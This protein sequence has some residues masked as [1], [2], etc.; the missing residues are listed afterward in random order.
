MTVNLIC[1]FCRFSKKVPRE[2]IPAR[3]KW[4][5]CPQCG[6]RFKLF[7]KDRDIDSIKKKTDTGAEYRGPEPVEM[8]KEIRRTDAPW[9]NRNEL[10]FLQGILQTLKGVLFSPEKFFKKLGCGSGIKEPLAFALL[11]G[12]VGS[13]FGFFWQFLLLSGTLL[14]IAKSFFGQSLSVGLIFL[15]VMVFI[16]VF[17][18]INL[19]IYSGIIHVLMRIVG[20]GK[21]GFEATFRVMSYCHAAQIWVIIPFVGSWIGGIWQLVVQIIGLREIHRTSYLRVIIAFLIP[22]VSIFLL[23]MAVVFILLIFTNRQLIG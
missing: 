20:A 1:P 6:Q 21:N 10:G 5:T 3:A 4:A 15:I 14:S 8:E 13:M 16:P 17:V 2:K 18:V 12:S 9:E 7:L 22:V 23:I 19:F 11:A